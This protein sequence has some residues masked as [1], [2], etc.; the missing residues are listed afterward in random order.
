ME[1]LYKIDLNLEKEYI[2]I[3]EQLLKIIFS[4]IFLLLVEGN[5]K[6]DVLSLL[7]YTLVGNLFYHLVFKKIIILE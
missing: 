6:P 5:I 2:D 7:T 1:S 4:Y 3:I